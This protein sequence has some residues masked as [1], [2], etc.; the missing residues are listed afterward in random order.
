MTTNAKGSLMTI[1]SPQN[2]NI[3][4]LYLT[5]RAQEHALTTNRRKKEERDQKSNSK[6][7]KVSS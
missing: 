1:Q 5:D 6:Q 2:S 3:K 4:D 7:K